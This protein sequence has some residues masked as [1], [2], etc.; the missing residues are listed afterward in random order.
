[1]VLSILSFCVLVRVFA[2][3]NVYVS[4]AHVYVSPHL[5]FFFFLLLIQCL[6]LNTLQTLPFV[7]MELQV[8]VLL[9]AWFGGLGCVQAEF[10]TSIGM[11]PQDCTYL[12]KIWLECQGEMPSPTGF[13]QF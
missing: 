2:C 9:V 4:S 8:S 13:D 10:F 7:T 5:I 11:C 12:S 1:M 3:L 6:L